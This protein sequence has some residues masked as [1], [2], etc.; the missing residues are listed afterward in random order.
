MNKTIFS[1]LAIGIA[2]AMLHVSSVLMPLIIIG[3]LAIA[4]IRLFWM[5][6]QAFSTPAPRPCAVR[7]N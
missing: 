7:N 1:L 6:L 4:T 3:G 5:V 2:L